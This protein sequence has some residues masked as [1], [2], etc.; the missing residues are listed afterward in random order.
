MLIDD[1]NRDARQGGCGS[2]EGGVRILYIRVW[3]RA[4]PAWW[5]H[6][7]S[8]PPP[9]LRRS[10]HTLHGLGDGGGDWW[11]VVVAWHGQG[12]GGLIPSESWCCTSGTCPSGRVTFGL[13]GGGAAGGQGGGATVPL[14]TQGEQGPRGRRRVRRY[15]GLGTVLE[16]SRE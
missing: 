6:D 3:H 12:G 10:T 8:A 5:R 15:E 9:S 13:G 16:T 7:L 4:G 1:R 11:V 14:G 2:G